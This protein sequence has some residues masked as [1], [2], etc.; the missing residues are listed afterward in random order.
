MNPKITRIAEYFS[1]KI[2]V[3][4]QKCNPTND[5]KRIEDKSDNVLGSFD[6]LIHCLW[7]FNIIDL[8]EHL[9]GGQ[10]PTEIVI[11][12]MKLSQSKMKLE[13][14]NGTVYYITNSKSQCKKAIITKNCQIEYIF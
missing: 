7:N 2:L 3:D 5:K 10:Q 1:T 4:Q 12:I 13:C 9:I 8:M 6:C 11:D 14:Y